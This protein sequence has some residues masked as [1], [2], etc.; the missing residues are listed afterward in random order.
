M[1]TG[2]LDYTAT[3]QIALGIQTHNPNV[4]DISDDSRIRYFYWNEQDE[5]GDVAEHEWAINGDALDYN[6]WSYTGRSWLCN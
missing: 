1:P 6:T 4:F 2:H 5:T 3:V